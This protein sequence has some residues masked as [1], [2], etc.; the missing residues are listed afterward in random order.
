[1]G[2]R[3]RRPI[4]SIL[5]R[6]DYN[7][8][9]SASEKHPPNAAR[10]AVLHT[11]VASPFVHFVFSSSFSHFYLIYF[12]FL[13]LYFLSLYIFFNLNGFHYISKGPNSKNIHT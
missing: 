4:S 1:M 7:W 12:C 3:R 13:I 5:A 9:A 11:V 6:N 8:R 10:A 2:W